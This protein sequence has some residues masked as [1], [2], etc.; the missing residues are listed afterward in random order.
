MRE[1]ILNYL[2][3]N[4]RKEGEYFYSFVN[5]K[6]I[7][8]DNVLDNF[9]LTCNSIFQEVNIFFSDT[10]NFHIFTFKYDNIYDCTYDNNLKFKIKDFENEGILFEFEIIFIFDKYIK[11]A[12]SVKDLDFN[13][14]VEKKLFINYN[15]TNAEKVEIIGK[16]FKAGRL[17][18]YI[19][20]KDRNIIEIEKFDI[21]FILV[22]II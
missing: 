21:N 15:S 13:R 19:E 6:K 7:H 9:K 11:D 4:N 12:L 14:I 10:E 17:R 3:K 1:S 8:K 22:D 18:L 2:K 5:I 16:L 20:N